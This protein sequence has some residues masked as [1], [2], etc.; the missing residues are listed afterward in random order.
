MLWEI[1]IYPAT[2][3]PD[4]IGDQVAADTADLGLATNL[5]VRAARGYLIQGA[6][7]HAQVARIAHELLADRI[8]ERTVV[9]PV[10]DEALNQAP[11]GQPRLV[12]VLP[13]PGVMDPVAQSALSA[14][15]D[16]GFEAEA[17]RTLKKYWVGEL[18]DERLA[19]LVSKILANDA[20]EQA[21]VGPL[22]FE[23][24]EVGSPY[25]FRLLHAPIREMNDEA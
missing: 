1:D 22:D 9:A 13:K 5:A 23:A 16:L 14:I 24:L 20:V 18:D 25:D 4:L 3:Q 10:G 6:L 12:H 17:V 21:I 7:D 11:N 8:V 2:G 15:A 19:L